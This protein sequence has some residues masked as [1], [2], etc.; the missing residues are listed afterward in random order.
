MK[1]LFLNDTVQSTLVDLHDQI[2]FVHCSK[3]LCNKM[4]L[5]S[6]SVK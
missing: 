1:I 5:F 3:R 6:V 2:E 4:I